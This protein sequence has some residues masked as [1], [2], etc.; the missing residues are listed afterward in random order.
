M[1]TAAW[2]GTQ[3][4]SQAGVYGAGHNTPCRPIV[5]VLSFRA[6]QTAAAI[7][8]LGKGS[9]MWN[10]AA[11]AAAAAKRTSLDENARIFAL[12][13]GCRLARVKRPGA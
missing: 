13:N 9:E 10:A 12:L 4:V 7:F 1:R 11:R 3:E 2:P 6:D 8:S 5:R